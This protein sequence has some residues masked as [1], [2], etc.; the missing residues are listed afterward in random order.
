LEERLVDLDI[1]A[2][3]KYKLCQSSIS[4][5]LWRVIE[6]AI[7]GRANGLFW[8]AKLSMDAFLEPGADTHEVLKALPSDLNVMYNDLLHEHARR[9]A[10]PEDLQ[11]L[12][13]QFVTHATRPLRILEIAEM[14][15]SVQNS[16]GRSLKETKDLVRAACG[17]LLEILPDETVSVVHHS[18]TEFLKGFTHSSE[19]DATY[20]ILELGS[21][22]KCLAIACLD[23][24]RSGCLVHQE[25]KENTPHWDTF[26]SPKAEQHIELKLQ[27]PFLEYAANNWY[28]HIRRGVLAG[29]DMSLVYTMLDTF[30]ADKQMFTAW[31]VIAWPTHSS[32]GITALHVAACTGLVR[33]ATHLLEKGDSIEA[34]DACQNTPL[35]WAVTSGHHDVAQVLLANG[36]DPNAEQHHGYKSPH[37][38]AQK[39][40]AGVV[41]LLLAAG[42]D[43][44]TPKT[45]D[46]SRMCGNEPTTL[47]H[48]PLMYACHYG[49][50]QTVAE[51]LPFL[52]N[53]QYYH[54][55]LHWA[56]SRQQL[57]SGRVDHT[58]SRSGCKRELPR[59]DCSFYGLLEGR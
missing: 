35:C 56:A 20:P 11:L 48:T 31:R 46:S 49:H 52:K 38:A 24:L 10:V 27:F 30:F 2:Y 47:G 23:Y 21:T 50:V 43:P 16:R 28:A 17:P 1:A 6:E 19:D 26:L 25:M 14:A 34:R 54:R 32:W 9:S 33:Y 5:E 29:G 13:L 3:V 22:N 15:R 36:A 40:H 53:S 58:A 37:L 39:N 12:V 51:F 41:K 59:R 57:C 55:A 44:L 42:V 7:P 8:Y 18:F 4:P 45:K